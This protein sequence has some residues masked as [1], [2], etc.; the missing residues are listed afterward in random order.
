MVA[1]YDMSL[2]SVHFRVFEKKVLK[3]QSCLCTSLTYLSTVGVIFS[4]KNLKKDKEEK[5]RDEKYVGML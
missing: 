3:D 5:R 1:T 4:F 2:G